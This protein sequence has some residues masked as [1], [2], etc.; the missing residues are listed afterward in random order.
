MLVQVSRSVTELGEDI[1]MKHIYGAI[2]GEK[3]RV[4]HIAS[5]ESC[6]TDAIAL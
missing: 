6:L 4:I 3:T 5:F 2:I 1:G